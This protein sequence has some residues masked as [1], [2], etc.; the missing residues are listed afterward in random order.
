MSG[1]A[2]SVDRWLFLRTT[3]QMMNLFPF[4]LVISAPACL[5]VLLKEAVSMARKSQQDL[6]LSG[7]LSNIV[8]Q[9]VSSWRRKTQQ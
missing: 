9:A 5:Q 1:A 7:T 6:F 8:T 4:V 2:G 3:D